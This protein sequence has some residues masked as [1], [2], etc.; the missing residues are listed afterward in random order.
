MKLY[1]IEQESRYVHRLSDLPKGTE[2]VVHDIPT[3]LAGLMGL[4]NELHAKAVVE[5]K[6]QASDPVGVE[7]M[8]PDGDPIDTAP[9]RI[10]H[11]LPAPEPDYTQSRYSDAASQLARIDNPGVPVD[12]IVETIGKSSGYALRRYSGAVATRFQELAK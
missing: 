4:L 3:D 2:P 10:V 8:F 11:A 9:E 12:Q 6:E 5:T 1:W 7:E